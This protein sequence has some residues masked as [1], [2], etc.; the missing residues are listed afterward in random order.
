MVAAISRQDI[1]LSIRTARKLYNRGAVDHAQKF[2]PVCV[3]YFG[4]CMWL[5]YR[6]DA[7][8]QLLPYDSFDRLNDNGNVRPFFSRMCGGLNFPSLRRIVGGR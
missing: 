3:M 4:E 5:T 7:T 1:R 8:Y 2:G 6:S